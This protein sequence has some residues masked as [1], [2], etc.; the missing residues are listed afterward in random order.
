M[1]VR[2]DKKNINFSIQSTFSF[3]QITTTFFPVFV[4]PPLDWLL[5]YDFFTFT[6]GAIVIT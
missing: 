5:L 4:T 1:E 3:N 6:Q 2:I